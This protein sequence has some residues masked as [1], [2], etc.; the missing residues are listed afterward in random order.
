[1]VEQQLAASLKE[2]FHLIFM[3]EQ[4]APAT[5]ITKAHLCLCVCVCVC[6]YAFG[7][8][9][10]CL[11]LFIV[12]HLQGCPLF[13]LWLYLIS[14]VCLLIYYFTSESRSALNS[15]RRVVVLWVRMLGCIVTSNMQQHISRHHSEKQSNV[16]PPPERKLPKGQ[17]TLTRG[18]ASPL[19][20]NN[21]RAQPFKL[22]FL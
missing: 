13:S 17:T 5:F 4:A 7:E 12:L 8:D 3:L 18:F 15:E 9:A 6:V 11:L 21:A 19:P 20:L 16:T 1:M 14:E 10:S 2:K 22:H